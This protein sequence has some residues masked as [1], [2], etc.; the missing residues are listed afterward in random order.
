MPGLPPIELG[1]AF[2]ADLVQILTLWVG[3][4]M[5]GQ[6]DD[7][8]DRRNHHRIDEAAKRDGRWP[9]LSRCRWPERRRRTSRCRCGRASDIE[10]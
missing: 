2:S 7:D 10:L 9:E 5:P 6:A 8:A 1:L 4:R 3:S